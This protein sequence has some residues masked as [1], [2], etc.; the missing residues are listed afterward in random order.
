MGSLSQH[1]NKKTHIIYTHTL[2]SCSSSSNDEKIYAYDTYIS[3]L[4]SSHYDRTSLIY[5]IY[6]WKY[7]HGYKSHIS[8][9]SIIINWWMNVILVSTEFQDI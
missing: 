6:V 3:D 8:G 4:F 7:C 5:I 1:L 2:G 9:I